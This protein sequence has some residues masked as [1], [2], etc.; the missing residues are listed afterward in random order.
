MDLGK[1]I[2]QFEEENA[3]NV[4]AT[5]MSYDRC[6]FKALL[7]YFGYNFEI[8][9]LTKVKILAYIKECKDN[10]NKNS[11]INKHL[12][13]IYRLMKYAIDNILITLT[14]EQ[15]QQYALIYKIGTLK[16]DSQ[17]YRT[18]SEHQVVEL[19]EYIDS[20]STKK[21]LQLRNKIILSLMLST[22]VRRNELIHIKISNI[23]F[24]NNSIFLEHTKTGFTRYIYFDD[25][26]GELIKLL[27]KRLNKFKN[28]DRD[29]LF[30]SGQFHTQ[31]TTMG[32][33][34]IFRKLKTTLG[35]QIAPHMLRHTFATECVENEIPLSSLQTLMGHTR[36][37]TTQI[38][39][40][41][42]NKRVKKDA[43]K[44]NPLTKHR[45]SNQSEGRV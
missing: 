19:V 9:S 41:L 12:K 27:I 31:L 5:T 16:D 15:K 2:E 24:E 32:I 28:K 22:G 11:T 21:Y 37:S 35:F 23:D 6:Q 39:I 17:S 42:A 44:Y 25:E 8:E 40:H 38:Y 4:R 7:S 14:D 3:L 13:M 34:E 10:N 30:L 1:I 45:Q 36:L 43:L 33:D 20:L 26:T 18:L 29:W